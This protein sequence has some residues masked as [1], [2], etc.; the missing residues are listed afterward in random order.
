M[1]LS[2]IPVATGV[3]DPG[4]KKLGFLED[5]RIKLKR[6]L[7]LLSWKSRPHLAIISTGSI[8]CLGGERIKKVHTVIQPYMDISI[9]YTSPK[10]L[11]SPPPQ[12]HDQHHLK[13]PS[14]RLCVLESFPQLV[15]YQSRSNQETEITSVIGTGNVT[16]KES[17]TRKRWLTP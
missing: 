6:L 3:Y 16:Y 1:L 2:L 15:L 14:F 11:H 17:L 7:F 12:G 9:Y 4:T 13:V 10:S 8:I 5:E